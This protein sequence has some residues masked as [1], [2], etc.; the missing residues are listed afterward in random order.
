M[1]SQPLVK[2]GKHDYFLLLVYIQLTMKSMYIFA[3][4]MLQLVLYR[5]IRSYRNISLGDI[6]QYDSNCIVG[7]TKE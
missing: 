7:T 2:S 4:Q 5:D 3:L 6:I 1:K